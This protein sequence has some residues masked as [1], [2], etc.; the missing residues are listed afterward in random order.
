[1]RRARAFTGLMVLVVTIGSPLL[2]KVKDVK[3]RGYVTAVNSPT[4]F[5][6]EDYRITRDEGFALDFENASP[7]LRFNLEDIRVGVELEIKGSFNDVTGELKAKSIKVDMEQFK[8]QKQTAI[9]A[10]QPAGVEQAPD[11]WTGTFLVD[12]QRIQVTPKT[13]VLFKLTSREKKLEKKAKE[14]AADEG[15]FEPLRSLADVTS[16]MAMTYEGTRDRTGTI[17]ADR[18]EFARNDLEPGEK[19][20]WDS[21]KVTTKPFN[22]AQALAGEL[23]IA[24]VGKFKN[25][26]I[27]KCRIT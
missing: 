22:A 13:R 12:G 16:G 15:G 19:K 7:D 23:K 20:M 14:T 25:S 2:A 21:L 24:Q 4:Q 26:Q 11:G 3:I 5:E 9:L 18:V 17:V 10:Q 27:K 1:M 6:I 8:P